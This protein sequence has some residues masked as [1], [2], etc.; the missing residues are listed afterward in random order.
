MLFFFKFSVKLA[1]LQEN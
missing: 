1:R